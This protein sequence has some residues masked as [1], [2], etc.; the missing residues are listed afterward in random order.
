MAEERLTRE[1]RRR[2]T[3]ERLLAASTV[4]F[5]RAGMAEADIA[6]I[7]AEA[8]VAHSTFFFHFP[9]KEHVLIELEAREERRMAD[10]FTEFVG[11]APDLGTAL[12]KAV[13][14]LAELE[15]RLGRPLFRDF[16][17][18]HFSTTRPISEEGL[19][20]PLV[21]S[22]VALLEGAVDEGT[23]DPEVDAMNSAIF[24]LLGLYALLVTVVD[25]PARAGILDDYV[26]RTVRSL[27]PAR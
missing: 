2:R 23:I 15:M 11:T 16:L 12:H 5:G 22:V 26:T 25:S 8:G 6:K 3:R 18:S 13:D 20:H 7:V 24:F 27:Q 14:L 21:L 17:A 19:D 4:E 1:A 10:R 9:T